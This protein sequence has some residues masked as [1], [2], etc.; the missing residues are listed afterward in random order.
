MWHSFVLYLKAEP[1][2][3]KRDNE[4]KRNK[5]C[6]HVQSAEIILNVATLQQR[7]KEP[8]HCSDSSTSSFCD[9]K[10]ICLLDIL[11]VKYLCWSHRLRRSNNHF[12]GKLHQEPGHSNFVLL[13]AV[14]GVW[15]TSPFLQSRLWV[16]CPKRHY[17]C[18]EDFVGT[19]DL[20]ILY[21]GKRMSH[22]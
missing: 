1:K 16:P 22:R 3:V 13:A 7:Q 4:M 15:W 9:F 14:W 10:I 18:S 19:E 6:T 20:M 2:R 17:H 11:W 21:S 5:M 12:E 8:I